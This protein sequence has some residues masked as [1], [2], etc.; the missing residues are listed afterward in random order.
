[1]PKM[2]TIIPNFLVNGASGEV[3]W[4]HPAPISSLIKEDIRRMTVS[5]TCGFEQTSGWG[6]NMKDFQSLCVS[7]L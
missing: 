1:M 7:A 5:L 6:G 4:L 2:L 3:R